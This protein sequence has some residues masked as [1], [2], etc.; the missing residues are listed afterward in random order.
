MPTTRGAFLHNKWYNAR[1]I[2]YEFSGFVN[3]QV[4]F[5]VQYDIADG[6]ARAL[7]RGHTKTTF[8]SFLGKDKVF[9]KARTTAKFAADRLVSPVSVIVVA[10]NSGSMHFDDMLT[11]ETKTPGG[12]YQTYGANGRYGTD[13]DGNATRSYDSAGEIYTTPVAAEPR[14]ESLK[15]ATET[16]VEIV[17]NTAE[18]SGRRGAHHTPGTPALQLANPHA[19]S[20]GH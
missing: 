18:R 20:S 6:E 3:E 14:I 9:F 19:R 15:R 5:K 1:D 16:F 8:S 17:E 12:S 2:G 11:I 10:D 13:A 7:V 4:S